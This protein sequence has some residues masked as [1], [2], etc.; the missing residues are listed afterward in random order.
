MHTLV[1]GASTNPDRVSFAAIHRL[2]AAGHPVTALGL[3]AGEVAGIPIRTDRPDL[4]DI[5][6]VTL[7]LNATN[8]ADWYDYILALRPRRI[9]FNPGTENPAFFRAAQL[10]GIEAEYA[11]TLVLLATDGY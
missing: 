4:T 7:Y 5:D 1:I 6:T 11:C 2:V 10:A 3:R 9:I 8:Q